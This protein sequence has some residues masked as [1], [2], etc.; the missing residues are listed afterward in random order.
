MRAPYQP[1][2]AARRLVR[3]LAACACIVAA[4]RAG[5]AAGT[6]RPDGFD[7]ASAGFRCR[8]RPDGTLLDIRIPDALIART[9]ILHAAYKPDQPH[10]A[11]LFQSG[12][13]ESD[14]LHVEEKGRD[15]FVVTKRGI[16]GNARHARAARFVQRVALSPAQLDVAYDIEL[17][18]T[19]RTSGGGLF[20]VLHPVPCETVANRGYRLDSRLRVFPAAYSK[21]TQVSAGGREKLA[22]VLDRAYFSFVAEPGTALSILDCRSWGGQD[23]RFDLAPEQPWRPDTVT[24]EAG[25]R[26]R[27]AYCLLYRVFR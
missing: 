9:L 14:P 17:L 22:V 8:V 11:R 1:P 15:T 24:H 21:A 13:K 16:L 26:F 7:Y 2:S 20:S 27:I 12:L 23:Y 25:A 6:A 18:V 4:P 19:L 3:V 10:D 5:H